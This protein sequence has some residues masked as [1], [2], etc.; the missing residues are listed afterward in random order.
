MP[1]EF[2]DYYQILGVP[3]NASAEDVKKSFRTL[4][5]K[6][7]PDVAQDKKTAETKFKDIN[8]AYEVLGDPENRRKYDQ[9]GADWK[10]QGAGFRQPPPGR[11]GAFRQT[12]G[13][14]TGG[15]EFNFEF[16]GTGFSD[17]F[18][19]FFGGR[20]GR[21]GGFSPFGSRQ[22]RGQDYETQ[23]QYAE[24]QRGQDIRGDILITLEEVLKGAMRAITVRR[25]NA[26]TGQEESQTYQVRIPAGVRAGQSIRLRGK[27]DAGFAG[28]SAGDMYLRVRYAQ[29]PDFETR[30][31]DLIGSLELAPWEAVLGATVPVQTLEGTVSLKVPAGTQQGNQLRARSKG[32]PAGNA[33]RGD[34]YVGISIQVPPQA[35]EEEK[36]LWKQLED[37]SAFNP[38]NGE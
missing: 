23:E 18:E 15:E 36:R 34:L 14:G 37:K 26:H 35:S 4:A 29:H 8:E 6:Y 13:R 12:Y 3:R 27:G 20:A 17:F 1:L 16:E 7:H 5:R 10:Q 33:K 28:G 19:Q 24:A 25:T 32:L 2:K 31:A 30:G 21:S 11:E 9:L 22:A 38:R